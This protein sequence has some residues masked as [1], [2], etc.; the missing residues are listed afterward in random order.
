MISLRGGRVLL[1]QLIVRNLEDEIVR[2]LKRRAALN[3][4]SAEEEHRELLRRTLGVPRTSAS[5]K[6]LLLE[7]P[8]AGEDSDFDRP[9]DRGRPVDL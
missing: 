2:E 6:Q 9:R 4:R 1:A 5:L 7:M 8:D 3:G